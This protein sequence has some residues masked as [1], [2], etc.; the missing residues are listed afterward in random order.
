LEKNSFSLFETILSLIILSLLVSGFVQFAYKPSFN[1]FSI[2][3]IHNIFTKKQTHSNISTQFLT[4]TQDSSTLFL[5]SGNTILKK[6]YQDNE[7]KMEY[8]E[9]LHPTI[10]NNEFENFQ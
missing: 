6:T 7:L 9:L 3:D 10:T 8:L 4:Y 1:S 5:T 2:N